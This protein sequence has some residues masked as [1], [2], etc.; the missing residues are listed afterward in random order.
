M[1]RRRLLAL[2]AAALFTTAASV[3]LVSRGAEKAAAA[4]KPDAEGF[5]TLFDGSS[6]E[7][8]KANEHQDSFKLENGELVAKGER[9]HLFYVGPVNDHNFKNFHLRVECMTK[10]HANSGIYFHTK[11]Q[12]EG[13]PSQGVEVQV[14]QTHSDPKKTGGLYAIKDVMNV[15]PVKDNEWYTYDIE[16]KDKHVNIKVN[17]KTTADWTQPDDWKPKG[18]GGRQIGSG[19]FALQGHDPGS[20]VMFRN[21]RVKPM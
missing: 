14:N 4:A 10:P 11:F 12:D 9:A 2:G 17:G 16:V 13:W 5:I 18:F 3:P 8:W 15:S 20:K 1:N 19:T 21:I 6:L 7:D